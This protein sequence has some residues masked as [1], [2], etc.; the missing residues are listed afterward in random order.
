MKTGTGS[1]RQSISDINADLP[2]PRS[3]NGDYLAVMRSDRELKKL[4]E[5]GSISRTA[6]RNRT[7]RFEV[8][9]P[10]PLTPEA[11]SRLLRA[12][13]SLG[14]SG[15]SFTPAN[16]VADFGA[17]SRI[18]RDVVSALYEAIRQTNDPK[19]R[20]LFDQWRLLFS[21]V[22]GYK[23]NE[24][25]TAINEL[26]KSF[27]I[28]RPNSAAFLFAL[29]T[30]YSI[31]IKLLSSEIV[32]VFA[33]FSTSVIQKCVN[34]PTANQLRR[35]FMT[36]EGGS[37]WRVWG[38]SNFLEGDLFAWYLSAWTPEISKTLRSLAATADEY[39]PAT[40]SVDPGE[41]HDLLKILYQDLIPQ[42]TRHDL[43]EYYTPDWL[44]S[45]VLDL[46]G[47][48]GNP[49]TRIL[50]P[51]CGSGTFLVEIINRIRLWFVA[52]RHECGFSEEGLVQR[53]LANVVGFDLNPLAVMASRVNCLLVIRDLIKHAH[54]IELPVFLS[55]SI[56]TPSAFGELLSAQCHAAAITGDIAG[57]P[58]IESRID[59]QAS[60]L[61]SITAAELAAAR[62]GLNLLI[63]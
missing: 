11:I 44:A 5:N 47:Y 23:V 3:N 46:V 27:G 62:A 13:I 57:V 43:G 29:H 37:N 45:R 42:K 10:Q 38:V 16:L 2:L 7:G 63:S 61:F 36:L 40:L 1:R 55:D 35:E 24:P 52:H 4:N 21:E 14:A 60:E 51:G 25:N 49:D 33:T 48:D 8:D 17:A 58:G 26:A 56:L 54:H 31:F 32:S 15:T 19:A 28:S 18:A 30:Y 12:L 50:D 6:V 39:D 53:I 59:E 9:N 34:A 22:C 41:S 20:V